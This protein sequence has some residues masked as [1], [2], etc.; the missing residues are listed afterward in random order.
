K[1][2][3]AEGRIAPGVITG[4]K[5]AHGHKHAYRYEF[6]LL[7]GGV[8]QGKMYPTHNAHFVGEKVCVVYLPDNPDRNALYPLSMV[9]QAGH[10]V[11]EKRK[12]RSARRFPVPSRHLTA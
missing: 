4:V 5:E 10:F 2:L 9:R 1:Y 11:T 8:G 6:P 12:T 3:L 7:S